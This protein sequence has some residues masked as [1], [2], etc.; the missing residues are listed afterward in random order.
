VAAEVSDTHQSASINYLGNQQLVPDLK[1]A[2][3]SNGQSSEL[4]QMTVIMM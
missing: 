1:A 4:L 2:G 3:S